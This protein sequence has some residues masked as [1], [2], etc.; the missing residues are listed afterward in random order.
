MNDEAAYTWPAVIATGAHGRQPRRSAGRGQV[1]ATQFAGIALVGFGCGMFLPR[2]L[3]RRRARWRAREL[4]RLSTGASVWQVWK[5]PACGTI[6]R[7]R[8]DGAE[9]RMAAWECEIL[10]DCGGVAAP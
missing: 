3:Q 5:C 10:H 1:T 9:E 7:W 8:I 6:E 2:A 4:R